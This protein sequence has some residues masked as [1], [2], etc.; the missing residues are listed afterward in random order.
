MARRGS[1]RRLAAAIVSRRRGET[2][3]GLY[4]VREQHA[5]RQRDHGVDAAEETH[6]RAVPRAH[7]G[8]QDGADDGENEEGGGGELDRLY[9]ELADL[10]QDGG[11]G[12]E[13][14][15]TGSPQTSPGMMRPVIPP[16]RELACVTTRRAVSR[17][18]QRHARRRARVCPGAPRRWFWSP[19]SEAITMTFSKNASR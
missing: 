6:A 13:V 2:Q 4:E 19:S 10:S 9:D 5:D 18:G 1:E 16:R 3:A 11:I 7:P 15:P 17:T 12:A 14:R 8:A